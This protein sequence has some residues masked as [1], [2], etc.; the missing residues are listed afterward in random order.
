M[1]QPSVLPAGVVFEVGIF[2]HNVSNAPL[3]K[4]GWVL[5]ERGLAP[6]VVTIVRE[7]FFGSAMSYMP[8][9]NSPPVFKLP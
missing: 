3:N 1:S 4:R 8:V 6:R 5:Q 2:Q 9:N 7:R